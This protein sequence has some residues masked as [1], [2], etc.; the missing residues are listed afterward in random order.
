MAYVIGKLG[1]ISFDYARK[2]YAKTT[3]DFRNNQINTI[4]N[5]ATKENFSVANSYR[6]GGEIRQ[7]KFS[8]RAGYKM[9][10]SPY[11]NKILYGDLSSYALGLGYNFGN[12]R[13]DIAYIN[14][15]RNISQKLY[16]S[17]DLN[18]T[19]LNINSSDLT[20][21]LSIDL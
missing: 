20:I 19:F 21:S 8:F 7:N 2:N 5:R 6:I 9:I 4:L 11:K 1:L 14:T 3:F 17:G 12:S 18:P 16:D 13:L 10:E 15:D